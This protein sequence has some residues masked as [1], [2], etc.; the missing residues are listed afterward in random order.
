M[1]LHRTTGKP[2]WEMIAANERTP[3]QKLASATNGVATPANLIS[4]IGFGIVIYGLVAL[5]NQDYWLGLG[6]LGLGRLLDIADGA[7]AQK[8]GTKSP[9]GEIVDTAVDKIGTILTILIFYVA[10]ISF[11]WLITAL[12]LPQVAIALIVFYKRSRGVNIHPTMVGKM[13]M[14]VLWVAL[15][16][17][18]L[19]QALAL[20][21]LHPMALLIY[22]IA[23]S[24]VALGLHTVWQY[25]TG[26]E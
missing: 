7:V 5:L 4:M 26:R 1:D 13:S 2:D 22:S 18:V 21:A 15:V 23:V 12:L 16:G 10:G 24:A 3:L 8:T 20:T 11:W 17:L 14:A 9:L 6:L 19:L 25:A